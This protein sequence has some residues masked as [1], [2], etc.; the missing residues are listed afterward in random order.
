MTRD[1]PVR[2]LSELDERRLRG[3]ADLDLI[4]GVRGFSLAMPLRLKLY[5]TFVAFSALIA[6]S[7]LG[8]ASAPITADKVVAALCFAVVG[9][10]GQLLGDPM[11]KTASGSISFIP[12]L[13]AA[14]VVPDLLSLAVIGAVVV[15][16]EVY[17]RREW[18]KG[19]FNAS[20]LVL[21]GA[22]AILV[23]RM[24]GGQGLLAYEDTLTSPV[25]LPLTESARGFL[26][27]I[28]FLAANSLLVSGVVSILQ[29]DRLWNVWLSHNRHTLA[30]DL[31]SLP[32]VLLFASVY[33]AWG[34][35]AI[36]LLAI[37]LLAFRHLYKTKR[38]LEQTNHELLE[39]MVAAIEAR[40][41]Y[42]SGHSRR[43]SEYSRLIAQAL[44]LSSREVERIATAGLLHDVGKIHEVFGDILRKPGKLTDEERL[45]METHPIKS[46]ELVGKVSRLADI[47][48]VVR[49]HHE[50]WDG[51][52]YPDGLK[53]EE[54]PLGSRVIMLADTIDAMTTDRPYRAA[55]GE[56][57][58]RRELMRWQGIQF[59]PRICE[60]LIAS[61]QF[62]QI[63]RQ[64]PQRETK[65]SVRLMKGETAAALA[66][67]S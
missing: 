40:D 35:L 20:Q 46:A 26:A 15:L 12:M 42:T 13:A 59:D 41:P 22:V 17:A 18:Y 61:E 44:G 9:T 48:D 6:I 54:I 57:E 43:V 67:S 23:Y 47:L 63:F 11:S 30:Y 34:G 38:Q 27:G 33:V 4:V 65:P 36:L 37:P 28:A 60:L 1:E 66:S 10:I 56:A 45:I 24:V 25:V 50:N 53:G 32:F 31:I 58:V 8:F 62:Q 51:S 16:S 29:G 52:G 2:S 49:H 7:A 5:V 3:H 21:S 55:L 39:L 64:I 14:L 19:L